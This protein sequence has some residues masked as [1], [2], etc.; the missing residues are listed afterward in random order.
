MELLKNEVVYS[1]PGKAAKLTNLTTASKK[2]PKARELDLVA[3]KDMKEM[4]EQVQKENEEHAAALR[5][6]NKPKPSASFQNV[7]RET[8]FHAFRNRTESPR[9]GRYFPKKEYVMPRVD[10]AIPYKEPDTSPRPKRMFIP[11]CLKDDLNCSLKNRKLKGVHMTTSEGFNDKLN[12]TISNVDEYH[13]R[14]ENKNSK[15]SPVPKKVE[16]RILS[17]RKFEL[18]RTRD[19]FV[20]SK[21]PPNENRFSFYQCTSMNY[22]RNK[23][24]NNIYF[25]KVSDRKE[26]YPE[27][28]SPGPYDKE[29]QKLMRR[30]DTHITEFF[31]AA[32]RQPNLV[33]QSLTT[34]K[35]LPASTYDNAH[36]RLSGTRGAFK[37]PSMKTTA[38]RDDLM[39]RTIEMY[40]LNVP[41]KQSATSPPSYIGY[42]S[43]VSKIFSKLTNR[44]NTSFKG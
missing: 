10:H 29:E 2:R 14:V 27:K 40:N 36:F 8:Y 16:P 24:V 12:R 6:K 41:E 32:S 20:T 37:I 4:L 26:L 15:W 3:V 39:Y 11:N 38:P 1:R 18:Q 44:T 28:H 21:D 31:K 33:K 43:D 42:S 7:S 17:A 13:Q 23:R 34:P 9:V 22:A 5:E 25:E 30:L 35:P 19:P